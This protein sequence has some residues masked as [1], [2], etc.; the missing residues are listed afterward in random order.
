MKSLPAL[1]HKPVVLLILQKKELFSIY[2]HFTTHLRHECYLLDISCSESHRYFIIIILEEHSC[3][4]FLTF[5]N[6]LEVYVKES[7]FAYLFCHFENFA[8]KM[9]W[10]KSHNLD[11]CLGIGTVAVW[12]LYHVNACS[13][14]ETFVF[15]TKCSRLLLLKCRVFE[16][17]LKSNS[18]N[19]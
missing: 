7:G 16:T 17:V 9:V 6:S 3:S 19:I 18:E 8:F 10:M 2:F 4:Y 14:T 1:N 12:D 15:N 5:V 11:L 13:D